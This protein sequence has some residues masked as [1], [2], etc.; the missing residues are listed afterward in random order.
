MPD[1]LCRKLQFQFGLL[2]LVV[3]DTLTQLRTE[4]TVSR[5]RLCKAVMSCLIVLSLFVPPPS[6]RSF[7]VLPFF[8]VIVVVVAVVV[9]V[10]V[11]IVV[12]VVLVSSRESPVSLCPLPPAIVPVCC[13]LCY[14]PGSPV[15]G[16]PRMLG[17]VSGIVLAYPLTSYLWD[18]NVRKID[19]G[20]PL[21]ACGDSPD[22]PQGIT[23]A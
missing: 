21:F 16:V 19:T 12:V 1:T 10:Y 13:C 15:V 2:D 4:R 23:V 9:V 7:I 22:G 8:L 11:V 3:R 6:F 20:T 17:I 14:R 5:G 18:S